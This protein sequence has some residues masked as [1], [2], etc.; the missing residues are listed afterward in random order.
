MGEAMGAKLWGNF[1]Y[2]DQN[3]N[4]TSQR[5]SW[6]LDRGN[7]LDLVLHIGITVGAMIRRHRYSILLLVTAMIGCGPTSRTSTSANGTKAPQTFS[8]TAKND[9]GRVTSDGNLVS[10]EKPMPEEP[11]VPFA[12]E[13]GGPR[14]LHRAE[15]PGPKTAPLEIAAFHTGNRIAASPIIGP[16]G[17]I[18]IGSIDGTFNALSR[19]GALRWSYI[20]DEP[21]FSTAAVS[22]TGKVFVGCDDDT[23]LAFSTDGTLRFTVNGRQDMDSSPVISDD[24]TISEATTS[25]RS[26]MMEKSNSSCGSART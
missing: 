7:E 9:A 6:K 2:S 22:Q 19:D 21:I 20:C 23:L 12:M 26:T 25:M 24:G 11:N 14:H 3:R 17:T 8:Q 10:N 5:D 16:D 4:R 1:P 13:G 18:Y 15:I